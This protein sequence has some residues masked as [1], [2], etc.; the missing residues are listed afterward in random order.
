MSK[1]VQKVTDIKDLQLA[2]SK[3]VDV[4]QILEM[5]KNSDKS[6]LVNISGDYLTLELGKTYA[7][8]CWG[9]SHCAIESKKEAGKMVDAVNLVT[10]EG[11]RVINADVKLVS[12]ISRAEQNGCQWP[13]YIVVHYKDDL[14]GKNG[15]YK[16]LDI[17]LVP[18][19]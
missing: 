14:K 8:Q 17:F 6:Q 18:E 3:G 16:D 11:E 13:R 12:A 10:D 2:I 4:A 9:I 1:Q 15:T 5:A 19:N 7:L